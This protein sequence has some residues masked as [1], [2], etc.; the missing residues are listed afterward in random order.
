M[1]VV[2][3]GGAVVTVTVLVMIGTHTR[4]RSVIFFLVVVALA[5]GFRDTQTLIPTLAALAG[6]MNREPDRPD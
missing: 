6:G 3:A 4:T 2:A 5:F 1:D